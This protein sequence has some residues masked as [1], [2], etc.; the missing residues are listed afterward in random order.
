MSVMSFAKKS[1]RLMGCRLR[2][3]LD[4]LDPNDPV[5]LYFPPIALCTGTSDFK[6]A[7]RP[8]GNE[9]AR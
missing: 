8:N 9:R 2:E 5:Q 7:G 4:S 3:M 1:G 6:R